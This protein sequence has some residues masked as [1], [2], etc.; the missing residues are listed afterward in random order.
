[1]DK[2]LGL[3]R[4]IEKEIERL[5]TSPTSPEQWT[6]TVGKVEGLEMVL[7]WIKELNALEI[8]EQQEIYDIY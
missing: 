2:F 1:M 7:V 4:H 3:Q 5:N 8:V 6:R